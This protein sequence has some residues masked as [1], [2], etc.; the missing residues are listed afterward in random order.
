MIF[1]PNISLRPHQKLIWKQFMK[2]MKKLA[3]D[4]ESGAVIA[5]M[6]TFVLSLHRR[7]GE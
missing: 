4:V 7:A 6:V 3:D 2:L 1:L 5:G